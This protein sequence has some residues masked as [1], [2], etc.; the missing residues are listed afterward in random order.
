MTGSA[1]FTNDGT[2]LTRVLELDSQAVADW[3]Q[4]NFNEDLL[5]GCLDGWAGP[6]VWDPR[7]ACMCNLQPSTN[8]LSRQEWPWIMPQFIRT[9]IQSR[10]RSKESN[11]RVE[12][13]ESPPALSL[14][15][16][17]SRI[18]CYDLASSCL[19]MLFLFVVLPESRMFILYT[20]FIIQQLDKNTAFL[21]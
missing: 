20:T 8:K 14:S 12:P 16:T 7:E 5:Q 10:N 4:F 9:D 17:P 21:S 15:S 11:Q 13:H 1:T 2:T 3:Y 6:Y 18:P 19:S